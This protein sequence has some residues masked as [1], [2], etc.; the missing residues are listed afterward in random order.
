MTETI[1][2]II[3]RLLYHETEY[4]I[5]ICREH[6]YAIRNIN[7]HLRDQ[8]TV[9]AKVRRSIVER[10]ASLSLAKPTD[11]RLPPP[12]GPPFDI[13]GQP[14][15]ALL[16]TETG[17]GFAS[18]ELTSVRRHCNQAHN[19]RS[20]AQ[21]RTH[22]IIVKAQ[23]FFTAGGLQRYFAVLVETEREEEGNDEV[24]RLLSEW[25]TA[26][27][28]HEEE[29]RTIEG[30][31]A[32]ADRT[33]W[34]NRTGWPEHLAGSNYKHLSHATRL[35]DRDEERL[36]KAVK[37]VEVMMERGITGLSTLPHETRRWLKSP[38]PEEP[39]LK[40]MARLQ[41]RESQAR[42]TRCWKRFVCY[43]LRVV[44][45]EETDREQETGQEEED[46]EEE[47]DKI[48]K[49][50]RRLFIWQERQKEL[51][52]EL[53]HSLE[54]GDAD[55]HVQKTL[56]LSASFVFI[57]VGGKPFSSGLIHFLAAMGIDEE[58]GRLRTADHYATVVAAMVYCARVVGAETLLPSARREEQGDAE[59]EEFSRQ[60]RDYLVDGSYSPTS[61][62]LSLLAYGKFIATNTGSSGNT[63][64][65]ADGQT[66]YLHGKPVVM[67]RF[68]AMVQDVVTRAE[69][70]L[71]DGLMWRAERFAV[72]LDKIVDDVSFVSTLDNGLDGKLQWMLAAMVRD[73]SAGRALRGGAGWHA[74]E[75]RKYIRGVDAFREL[76]LFAMHTTGGQPARGTEMTAM[77]H[78]NGFLQDRNVFVIDGQAVFVTRY[79]K[80]QSQWDSPKVVPRFLP[81]RVG[82]LLVIYLVYL[83]PFAEYLTVQVLGGGWTDYLWADA[84]GPW[85][86]DRLT[87]VLER[88]T[89]TQLGTELTTRSYRH[90][91]VTIGRKV[92]AAAFGAGYQDEVGEVEAAEEDESALELQNGRMTATGVAHYGVPIDIIKNLSMRSL[93]TFRPL[94]EKW[95][96]FL[97][98]EQ[99]K[100]EQG[101][102]QA[103]RRLSGEQEMQGR[104]KRR[105]D[106]Y[107]DQEIQTAM[108]QVL[109]RTEVSFRSAEQERALHDVL[110][111]RTP[112]VVVLPTGGGKSMLFMVPACMADAGVSIVV[113]PLRALVDD[114][115][116]R[117]K[118]AGIDHLEWQ[119]G[120]TNPAAVVV[121]SADTAVG[122]GFLSYACGL[123]ERGHLRRV[124]VDECHLALTANEWRTKLAR[125]GELRVLKCAVVLLTATL[126]PVLERELGANMLLR[127]AT[128]VRASTVRPN[129]RYTVSTCGKGQLE[130]TAVAT[131]RR[132]RL[133]Q[134]GVVYCRSKAQCETIAAALECAHYHA[135]VWDRA[136]RLEGWIRGGGFIVATSA[137]GTGVDISGIEFVLHVDVPWG[138]TDFAQASGRAGR[139]GTAG[140]LADSM[141]LVEGCKLRLRAGVVETGAT[142]RVTVNEVDDEAMMAFLRTTKCRRG[143]MSKYLDGRETQCADVADAAACDRCGE[144][145]IEWQE[146]QQREQREWA[147]VRSTLDKLADG[148]AVCWAL[149]G[150]GHYMHA[151]VSC[152]RYSR[153]T[154][155]K[156]D[157]FRRGIRYKGGSYACM[158]C[159][160]EQRLCGRGE[161]SEAPCHWA[162]VL[163]PIVRAAVED[164]EYVVLVRAEGY[165]GSVSGEGLAEYAAWLGK[166]YGRL[167]GKVVSNGM[168]V[169]ARV[170]LYVEGDGSESD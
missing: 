121:V 67:S 50:A 32:K 97:G 24:D 21:E 143:V 87:R 119:A 79:H 8:H 101:L 91:A 45:H 69:D 43:C 145:R 137:L 15:D 140:G 96:R 132:Q 65:S 31:T 115:V 34:F 23:T 35:P 66:L 114:L 75:V 133:G 107:S 100:S 56:Q 27:R 98:L 170:I 2:A 93:E 22:W 136:E 168:A 72:P 76:L 156:L 99:A 12:F 116:Q 151:R 108:Q 83:Q 103:K 135:G 131:C 53:V 18:V 95:H 122:N 90:V 55:D 150:D 49:D 5:L 57:K 152:G 19:W 160:V 33:G 159:G 102:E 85:E 14:V 46:T 70:M 13:L 62:M 59:L 61:T 148:C 128:Y 41:E 1:E 153:L 4:N 126:P 165:K 29:L 162:N 88:E 117:L 7:T 64:W 147:V 109:G 3:D 123:A 104:P 36:Q 47:E 73:G 138:M 11:V 142:A 54:A 120:E 139:G 84:R 124:V 127:S 163:V 130:E 112:L 92:V 167:W 48:L 28:M 74:R 63:S 110:G 129:I 38:K 125:L 86:T 30:E 161:D 25:Q 164:S 166:K 94:S 52:V 39:H 106:G 68:C 9:A 113:V 154:A 10:Y 144:G 16:C 80:S 141:V 78:R 44:G 169:M 51:A 105:R 58:M 42:Y 111:G 82:Q 6:S 89:Q 118:Q 149:D 37:A 157:E 158:K 146:K 60:R 40:P 71:W 77:R 134:K 155:A 81:W 26:K 20:T 17:C